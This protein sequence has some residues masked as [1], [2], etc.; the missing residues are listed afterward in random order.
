MPIFIT[1]SA[2]GSQC[3]GVLRHPAEQYGI[4]AIQSSTLKA[5]RAAISS[6][7][8]VVAAQDIPPGIY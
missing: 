4:A 3:N 8:A 1:S 7:P 2:P 6:K 5:S